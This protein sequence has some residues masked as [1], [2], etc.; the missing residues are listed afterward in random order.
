MKTTGDSLLRLIGVDERYENSQRIGWAPTR[1]RK[2][3]S[4]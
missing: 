3:G 1:V 2:R 4:V